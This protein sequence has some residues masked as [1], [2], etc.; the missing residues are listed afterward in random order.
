[1]IWRLASFFGLMARRRFGRSKPWT[2]IAG[3]RLNS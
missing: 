1:M 2:K 3:L